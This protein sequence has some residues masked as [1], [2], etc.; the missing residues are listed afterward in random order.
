MI[1]VALWSYS[2]GDKGENRSHGTLSNPC[3][4]N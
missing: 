4:Q 2:L 3:T 1:I